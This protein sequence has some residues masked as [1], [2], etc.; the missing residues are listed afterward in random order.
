MNKDDYQKISDFVFQRY[1]NISGFKK[2]DIRYY[3]M[4]INHGNL[5]MLRSG[6][7][8]DRGKYVSCSLRVGCLSVEV[9][10]SFYHNKKQY[11]QK[12][13]SMKFISN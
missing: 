10:K 1:E 12:L 4:E 13:T 5:S 11:G 3:P 6:G 9:N 2:N 8:Q 7:N